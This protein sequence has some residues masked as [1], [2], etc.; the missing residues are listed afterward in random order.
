MGW[1]HRRHH[2]VRNDAIT[3]KRSRVTCYNICRMFNID[4]KKPSV[5]HGQGGMELNLSSQCSCSYIG[6]SPSMMYFGTLL[7]DFN[8]KN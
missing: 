4:I 2:C 8:L 6:E 5:A 7:P 1:A 3:A